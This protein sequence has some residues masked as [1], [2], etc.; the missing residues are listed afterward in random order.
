MQ[1]TREPKSRMRDTDDR[2]LSRRVCA[3]LLSALVVTCLAE[4]C[5]ALEPERDARSWSALGADLEGAVGFGVLA[6]GS[7]TE[8]LGVLGAQARL[9]FAFLQVAGFAERAHAAADDVT[10]YGG[11][12]GIWL[13]PAEMPDFDFGLGLA[14]RTYGHDTPGGALG[15]YELSTPALVA[16]LGV[17][18]RAFQTIGGR[19]GARLSLS[20]DT[21]RHERQFAYEVNRSTPHGAPPSDPTFVRDSRQ[22]GGMS[23]VMTLTIALDVSGEEP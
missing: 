17:S 21:R 13:S 7:S 19:L 6:T 5:A 12:A 2:M 15:D 3:A 1:Y 14:A 20:W 18:D 9:R 23:V 16:R 8:S 22:V 10:T 4:P 11:V